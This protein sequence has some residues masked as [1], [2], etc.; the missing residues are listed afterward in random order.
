M[1][2]FKFFLLVFFFF[3]L[4]F[5][6]SNAQNNIAFIDI[7]LLL[8]NSNLGKSLLERF[9]KINKENNNKLKI[10]ESEL[11]KIEEEIK[12]KKNI[13]SREE[14]EKEINILK[15]EIDIFNQSK[16]NLISDYEKKRN[17]EISEFFI[18]INPI[19]QNYMSENSI[20]ILLERKNVFI[21]KNDS[22]I[23]EIIIKSIN[24]NL[25]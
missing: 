16:N 15:K 23:T 4:N 13:I 21:G 10:K 24:N 11:K 9:E 12:I 17:K 25:K 5:K 1:K 20:D 22:D 19:I 14:L 2:Y 18:K 7:D 3:F 8:K 6:I